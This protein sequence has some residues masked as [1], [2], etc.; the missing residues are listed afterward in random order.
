MPNVLTRDPARPGARRQGFTF[1]ELM[2]S[3]GALLFAVLCLAQ[4]ITASMSL[5]RENRETALALEAARRVAERIRSQPFAQV[6]AMYNS[7]DVDDPPGVSPGPAFDVRG[8]EAAEGDA[9][10]FPGE[11]VLPET[12][13]PGG[14][15]ELREDLV[16]DGLGMPRDLDG[17]NGVD[18]TDH[19]L[20]Y[21]VLPLLVRV[22]WWSNGQ[23]RRVELQTIVGNH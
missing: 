20:D 12:I 16:D 3:I 10:G 8:L 21:Q 13:G 4:A 11:I 19:A 18:T 7:T 22:E 6:F 2:F 17:L 15:V 9:D 1:I 14:E 23:N 5:S